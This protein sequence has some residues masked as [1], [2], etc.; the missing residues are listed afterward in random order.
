[1]YVCMYVCMYGCV[2]SSP[3]REGPLQLWQAGATLHRGARASHHRGPS[4]P[5]TGSRRAGPATAAHG[6]SRSAARG[7]LPDQ[8]PNPRSPHR[9]AD[10]QP[11]RHQGSPVYFNI[12]IFHHVLLRVPFLLGAQGKCENHS[13]RDS[14]FPTKLLTHKLF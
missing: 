8:G 14:M 6:P 7:I 10:S 9:Q 2:G 13:L 12:L 1:M 4:L 11:L 3:L 5:R